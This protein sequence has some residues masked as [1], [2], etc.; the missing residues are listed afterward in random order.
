MESKIPKVRWEEM[1]PSEFAAALAAKPVAYFPLGLLEWHGDHLPLGL[2]ALK[3]HGICCR[4][5]REIGGVVMPPSYHNRP[6]FGSFIGTLTY[7]ADLVT[8]MIQETLVQLEK[9]GFK[10]ALVITG[11]YGPVQVDTVKRAVAGFAAAGHTLRVWGGPEYEGLDP[12]PADHAGPWETSF[13]LALFP[14]LV[15]MD[16]FQKGPCPIRRYD[17]SWAD[18]AYRE[19]EGREWIWSEDLRATAAKERGERAIRAIVDRAR[20]VVEELLK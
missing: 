17:P 1:T 16:A 15:S 4:L 19:Q 5:A 2:D 7:S 20:E 18:P 3:I 13:A 6:G 10:A 8:A 14:E 11:H 12:A 9:C